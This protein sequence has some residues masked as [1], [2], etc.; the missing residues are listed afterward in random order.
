M[1]YDIIKSNI[2]KKYIRKCL[3]NEEFIKMFLSN[4]NFSRPKSIKARAD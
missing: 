4:P 1:S 3:T 2:K